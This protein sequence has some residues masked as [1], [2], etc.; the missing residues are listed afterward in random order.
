MHD[1]N[2]GKTCIYHYFCTICVCIAIRGR[3]Q[4]VPLCKSDKYLKAS[5]GQ[6]NL[7]DYI[8]LSS[9]KIKISSGQ[10]KIKCN[11][12]D[13]GNSFPEHTHLCV[14]GISVDGCSVTLYKTTES[15]IT[16]NP[17]CIYIQRNKA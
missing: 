6:S 7:N 2:S 10:S 4:T 11:C 13:C 15:P 8:F 1:I 14:I 12:H 9:F 3:P 17:S 5:G 16:D